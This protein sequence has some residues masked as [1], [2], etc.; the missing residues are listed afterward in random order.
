[1][2]SIFESLIRE[3]LRARSNLVAS[4]L[5]EAESRGPNLDGS[6]SSGFQD[7]FLKLL[8]TTLLRNRVTVV[9]TQDRVGRGRRSEHV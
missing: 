7:A 5:S 8:I 2:L 3:V 1:M 9:V 6:A 4:A